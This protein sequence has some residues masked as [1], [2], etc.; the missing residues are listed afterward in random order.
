MSITVTPVRFEHHRDA[1]GIGE[2]APRLSWVVESAPQ[3]AGAG[4]LRGGAARRVSASA[5]IAPNRCWCHG[6]SRRL[7]SRERREVRV[8]VV[9]E[10]GERVAVERVVAVEAG[11]LDGIRLDR[12]VRRS[13]GIPTDRRAAH[14]RP[15]FTVRDAEIARARVYASATGCSSSSSTVTAGRRRRARTR[16]DGVRVPAA[17]RDLRR[18]RADAARR[19]RVGAWLGDGWWRGHLGWDGQTRAVRQRA[20]RCSPSSRSSTPTAARQV[21]GSGADW[22]AGAGADPLR[23][24]LQRRGLR[25]A[26]ARPGV[27]DG[28]VRRRHMGAG[29]SPR[30][31]PDG[32]RRAGR[33]AGAASSRRWRCRTVTTSPQGRTILDFGQ[34][35]VGRLR[36]TVHGRRGRR[37]SPLRH[38]EVLEH[39]EIATAPLRAREGHR[40]VHAA[41]GDGRGVWAPRFTF[42][43]FRYAEVTGWPGRVRPRRGGRR[44]AAHRHGRAPAG[45]R[46]PTRSCDRLHENVVWGMR[47]NFVDVPTDCP[48][49]DERL[50]WT[51]DLQVFAPTAAF[52]YDSA[53]FLTSWLKDLAAEQRRPAARRWSSRAI[54]PGYTG[55]MAGWADAATVV[56]WTLYQASG[57]LDVLAAQF[58]EHDGVGRRGD[59]GRRRGPDLGAGFQFGDW[60]DPTAPAGRPEAAQTYPEIVATAY[61]ARSARIVADAAALLGR[62]DDAARYGALA[63]EVRAAFHREYVARS[64]RVLSDSA[65]AYALAL[66]FDLIDDPD[67]RR[68][69]ADRL[70]QIVAGERVPDLHRLH[71]DPA[72]HRRAERERPRRRRVPAAVADREPVL[73]VRGEA[74]RDHDL[75]AVGLAAAGRHRQPQRDD[76]VQP[77]RLRRG[78]RLD[79]PRRGRAR[80]RRSRATVAFGS[81]RNRRA[82]G[83][84]AHPRRSTPRTA[85]AA[86]AWKLVDGQLRLRRHRSGR[87]DRRGRPAVGLPCT[88]SGTAPTRS[89]EPFEVDPE[90]ARSRHRRHPLGEHRRRPAGDGRADR[91]DHEVHPGSRRAH[92]RRPPR[93]GGGHPAPDL[94]HAPAGPRGA[95]RPRARLRSGRRRVRGSR[96]M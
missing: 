83:S 45:S 10:D 37:S 31:R 81:P 16:M 77:L 15:T 11:L 36:I 8:R 66:Q 89:H 13:R 6:R 59:R 76:V 34:N 40:H 73:A 32:A 39:G 91:G 22:I 95:R 38:A 57:D 67:E 54:S 75:G 27:V 4:G 51:G 19:E 1:L 9:G 5:L 68:H 96:S 61:F 86:S 88:M 7:A 52:L 58:A 82:A 92:V 90:T 24:P 70:A 49:R 93:T 3:T 65:T 71:R 42:H 69:A 55:P 2:S 20:R 62:D 50:G 78:R 30:V 17:L 63:D 25:R 80:A 79:A 43:G 53:G 28:S 21:V 74:G 33:P 85:I 56:P 29:G 41:R 60:L 18:D 26:A 72:H 14:A 23:R 12:A 84:P 64:G 47:G 87:R 48:Q 46:H 94:R 35:L 44:G